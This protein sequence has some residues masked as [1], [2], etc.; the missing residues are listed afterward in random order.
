MRELAEA[1][2]LLVA[3]RL[4]TLTGPGGTG[5]TRLSLQIA[6]RRRR[7]ISRTA[8]GSWRSSRSATRPSSPRRSPGRSGVIDS[9]SR[10]AIELLAD[11]IG[12]G[13]VL[14]V[15]DNFEQVVGA[16]P[17]VAELLR[18]CPNSRCLVTTR[19]AAAR[20]GRAGVPGPRAARPARHAPPVRGRP[21]Q[22]AARTARVRCRHAEPVRGRPAVHRP[23]V[24]RPAGFRGHERERPG[25]GRDLGPAARHAAGHRARRGPDQAA[26][27]RTRSSPASSTTSPC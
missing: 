1:R 8:S 12:A 14:L 21:A 27:P 10:P 18:R 5:K 2:G 16:G 20:L 11:H 4:L 25:R 17:V 23:G 7:T 15:L 19:I 3:T 24:R 26:S 22:P 13:R 9:Q 6:A